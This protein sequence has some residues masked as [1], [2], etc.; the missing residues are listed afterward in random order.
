M[1]VSALTWFVACCTALLFACPKAPPS[2]TAAA[3][4]STSAAAPAA[5]TPPAPPAAP[6]EPL[7]PP[8]A[9]TLTRAKILRAADRRVVDDDLRA[10]LGDDDPAL[11]AAAVLALGQIGLPASAADAAHA[12]ADPVPHVRAVAAFSLGLI[13][14]PSSVADLTRLA[15]D[16]DTGVRAA[17]AEALG[18]LHDA[19]S[20]ATVRTLLGDPAS[21]VRAAA[22]LAAWKLP[23]AEP[24]LDPL[25]T[26]LTSDDIGFRRNAA[27]ALARLASSGIVPAS[28]GAAVGHITD[29]SRARI[30]KE[31]GIHVSDPDA[32]VRMQA[33]RGLSFPQTPEELAIVGALSG[34]GEPRVRVNAVRALGFPGVP[35]MPYLNRA[36]TDKD[37]HVSRAAL[38]SF[39]KVGGAQA[40]ERLNEIVMKLNGSWLRQAAL[41]S[42][43]QADPRSAET[44]VKGMLDNPDPLMR[45]TAAAILVGHHDPWAIH[46]VAA[47][48]GDPAPQVAAAAIPLIAATEGP[49]KK[50]IASFFTAPDPVVRAAAAEAVGTR[51][52]KIAKEPP[53]EV[54]PPAE[55]KPPKPTVPSKTSLPPK[56]EVAPPA[57]PK[58]KEPAETRAD[59][60]ADLETLWGTSAKDSIPDAK[61]AVLDAAAKAG[62]DDATRAALARGLGDPDVLVRRRAAERI[63][64]V[65]GEDHTSDIGPYTEKPLEDYV[66]VVQWSKKP[67][68]A[69]FTM[70][71]IDS[72]PG[73]FVVALDADAAPMT[74]FNF[75]QLANRK[76]FD[77]R[78]VHRVVPNFVVQDGDPRGDGF[79][80]PGYAI[81][82][83]WNPLA[84]TEGVVG[85]ASD[86]KD[87]AGS[88]WF[89]TLSA[90]PHLD[91]RYTS[92]GLVTQGMKQIVAQIMP[93][94][95]VVSVRIVE[96]DGTAAP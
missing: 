82:D 6:A 20:T 69:V 58:E 65:Y 90:Q 89:V 92:F 54:K 83:E 76:F 71:R 59:L 91:G 79:G 32:E 52:E 48:M 63:K 28:S 12:A 95:V 1:R 87:T 39:G 57:P 26:A 2:G 78:I 85:M 36:A 19:S 56:R 15:A 47:L 27:Y 77:G 45:A 84:Y 7:P 61:L 21:D 37:F 74:A 81:R 72:L 17:A 31:L 75:A 11:R 86:G 50:Q 62:K 64:D 10:A 35:V 51:F 23:D 38:E 60:F 96:G 42:L 4:A 44:I 30:R 68:A 40:A 80:G 73:R 22:A 8:D 25:L 88:Q 18:R 53:P 41:T 94:D 3:S 29:A 55:V 49:L 14:Q 70:Q 9:A 66:K 16:S 24:V 46:D 5:P 93:A 67:H 33:A 43:T 34:D 13:A